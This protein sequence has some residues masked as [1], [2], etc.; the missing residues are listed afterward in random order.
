MNNL[1]LLC[2]FGWF[3]FKAELYAT[4]FSSL[5]PPFLTC[6]RNFSATWIFAYAPILTVLKRKI[7]NFYL[8]DFILKLVMEV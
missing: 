6:S 5:F 4:N 8:E 1:Y 7:W 2:V 3:I